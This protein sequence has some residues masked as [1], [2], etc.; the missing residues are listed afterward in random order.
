M[1]YTGAYRW[2]TYSMPSCLTLF[3]KEQRC[4]WPVLI[5][6]MLVARCSFLNTAAEALAEFE[7]EGGMSGRKARYQA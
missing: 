2:Q 4:F 1:L 7:E 5:L 6:L 3:C